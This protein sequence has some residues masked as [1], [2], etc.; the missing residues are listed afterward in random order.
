MAGIDFSKFFG[1]SGSGGMNSI[2]FSDY[3]QIRNG[4][5]GKLLKSYYA[6][7]AP[8]KSAS[9]TDTTAKTDKTSKEQGAS[10]VYKKSTELNASTETAK[11]KNAADE[12]KTSA[13]SLA[14][15]GA[16]KKK[17]GTLDK[18]ALLKSVKEVANDY[19]A[20]VI[21]N[22]KVAAKSVTNQTQYMKNA[23]STMSKALEKVGVTFDKDGKMSV[24][25]DTFKKAEEKDLRAAFYGSHS[26][27]SQIASNATAIGSAAARNIATYGVD[28]NL[29][30]YMN[31]S[32]NQWT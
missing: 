27:A 21:Q 22:D 16:W 19:N 9:K 23:S 2:Y 25:E 18:D 24:N 14:N 29:S 10:K 13:E 31:Y 4:S 3:N 30:N 32:Y 28:G 6:K 1:S 8:V 20:V 11:M 5:Y 12:L 26:Y 15:N 17:N 7:T